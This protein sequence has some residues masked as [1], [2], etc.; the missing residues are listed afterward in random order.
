MKEQNE[1]KYVRKTCNCHEE[2]FPHLLFS[3]ELNKQK[4]TNYKNI[5]KH[6]KIFKKK[7]V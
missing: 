6:E 1:E 7:A 5:I 4:V 3:R 2:Y